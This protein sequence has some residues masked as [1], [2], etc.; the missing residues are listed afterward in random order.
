MSTNFLLDKSFLLKLNQHRVREY[1]CAILVLEFETEAPIARIEGKVASGQMNVAANS[2]TR[3]TGSL[4]LVF[5]KDTFDITN[6]NNLIAINKKIS[7]SIGFVNPFYHMEEY[8]KYGD[9][10]WFK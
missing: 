3:K 7:L 1:V 8:R 9:T 5:D 4:K 10:L 6:V 2:P